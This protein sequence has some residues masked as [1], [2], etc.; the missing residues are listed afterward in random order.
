MLRVSSH[1]V[2]FSVMLH[3]PCVSFLCS[4]CCFQSC[5]IPWTA[6]ESARHALVPAVGEMAPECCSPPQTCVRCVSEWCASV[7]LS[8]CSGTR[9]VPAVRL[10][11][12]LVPWLPSAS[13]SSSRKTP[14]CTVL[15]ICGVNVILFS[16]M[17]CPGLCPGTLHTYA[18]ALFVTP[19]GTAA[20]G[21]GPIWA[22]G[23]ETWG[24]LGSPLPTLYHL[25]HQWGQDYASVRVPCAMLTD[26]AGLPGSGL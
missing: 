10:K 24:C 2:K 5:V 7:C 6:Q 23:P 1:R 3:F 20:G 9:G 22:R 17:K 13:P 21:V 18:D 4:V 15:E 16:M 19:V 12:K 8:A 11:A 14:R 25:G 26:L